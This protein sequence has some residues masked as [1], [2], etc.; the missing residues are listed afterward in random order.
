MWWLVIVVSAVA[1]IVG[2]LVHF[3]LSDTQKVELAK[4]ISILGGL[5]TAIT[6]FWAA[7]TF[8]ANAELTREL[9]AAALYREH[10]TKSLENPKLAQAEIAPKP[11]NRNILIT[12]D[13]SANSKY[14]DERAD[15]EKYQWYV[16][17]AL[18]SFETMLEIVDDDPGWTKTFMAFVCDHRAYISSGEFP[19]DHY[20]QKLNELITA[21][22]PAKCTN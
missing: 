8:S 11:P 13:P 16:G 12:G 6:L 3:K 19:R 1:L 2:P 10:M 14:V 22:I 7:Y 21:T 20:S 5:S 4:T 17:H 15:F 18:Y 9:A